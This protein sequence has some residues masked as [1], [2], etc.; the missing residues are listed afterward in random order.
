[1]QLP[2]EYYWLKAH[3]FAGLMPWWFIDEPGGPGLRMEYQKETGED[4][5]PIAR[6]QDNDSVA[7]FK[8]IDGEIQKELV[9]VHL[10]WTGKREQQ[11]FPARAVYKDI[12]SWLSEEVLP[13]TADWVS[14]EF[15][16]EL[17][18]ENR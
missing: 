1:M 2:I 11:G 4:F 13:E 7:G 9:S 17:E 10:T 5:Y 14:K 12:F 15:L 6:R 16:A 3:K 18:E 8:V